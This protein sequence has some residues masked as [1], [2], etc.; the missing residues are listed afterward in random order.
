MDSS[1]TIGHGLAFSYNV[2]VNS[3]EHNCFGSFP[4]HVTMGDSGGGQLWKRF[5]LDFAL[6]A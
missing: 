2:E 3:R 5:E 6:K 4:H 1:S